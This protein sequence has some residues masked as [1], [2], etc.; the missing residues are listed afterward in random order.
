LDSDDDPE[1]SYAKTLSDNH[2]SLGRS[3]SVTLLGD[4]DDDSSGEFEG[5]HEAQ[6]DEDEGSEDEQQVKRVKQSKATKKG[7]YL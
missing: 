1:L 6:E 3:T 5:N 2:S 4:M 7:S